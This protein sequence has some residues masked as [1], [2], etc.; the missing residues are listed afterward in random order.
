MLQSSALIR[1]PVEVLHEGV[2]QVVV[3]GLA[4]GQV[5]VVDRLSGAFDGMRVTPVNP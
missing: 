1:Q 4:N 3:K 5:V 2:E